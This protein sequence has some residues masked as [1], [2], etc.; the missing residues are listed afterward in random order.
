MWSYT[1][2]GLKSSILHNKIALCDQNR[3]SYNQG[4]L[5]IK[6]Y[7]IEGPLYCNYVVSSMAMSYTEELPLIARDALGGLF[8][9]AA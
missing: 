9:E 6:G 7:K 3:W 2:V 8:Y 5:K 4:C 1:A